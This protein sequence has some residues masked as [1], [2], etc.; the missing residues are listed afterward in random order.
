[1]PATLP[2]FDLVVSARVLARQGYRYIVV[3]E[4][5]YPRYKLTQ[6]RQLLRALFGSPKEYDGVIVYTVPPMFHGGYTMTNPWKN[7]LLEF[8]I[9]IIWFVLLASALTWPMVAHPTEV[10]V[11]GGELG[12]WFWRQWWHF[13]E[14]QALE[15]EDLGVWGTI[16]A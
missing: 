3:H 1:M 14:V 8:L 5:F 12:G 4:K 10:I 13:S 6:T 9:A 11:G 7:I 15:N 16:E 2:Y